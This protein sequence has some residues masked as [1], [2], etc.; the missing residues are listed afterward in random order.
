METVREQLSAAQ[1]QGRLVEI[2]RYGDE[3]HFF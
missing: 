1:K 3:H 2:F